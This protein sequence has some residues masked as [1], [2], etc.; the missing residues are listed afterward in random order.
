MGLYPSDAFL[1]PGRG[2]RLML[3]C[4]KWKRLR[5]LRLP[6][7]M[8]VYMLMPSEAIIAID[9]GGTRLF[10]APREAL[11]YLPAFH[12]FQYAGPG[13]LSAMIR[14]SERLTE[15][16]GA[17]SVGDLIRRFGLVPV[18]PEDAYAS[19][20]FWYGSCALSESV[21][22]SRSPTVETLLIQIDSFPRVERP[23]VI[24]ACAYAASY[25]VHSFTN[26]EELYRNG[27]TADDIHSAIYC[28]DKA[29]PDG[30]G[31]RARLLN[32]KP[33]GSRRAG[34]TGQTM[35]V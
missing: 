19:G 12:R 1:M 9:A 21:T 25:V 29:G 23:R 6:S 13:A 28:G 26:A 3:N 10:S 34:S 30:N 27:V 4:W 31:F 18:C 24:R 7:G 22:G 15:S 35:T 32:G 16:I 5:F 2:R 8:G 33:P 20:Q 17:L 11:P 14:Q